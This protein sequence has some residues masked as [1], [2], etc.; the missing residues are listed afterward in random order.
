M[1][2]DPL[3][4]APV[5]LLPV[6][7][8]LAALLALDSYKLVRLRMVLLLIAGGG[9]VAVLGWFANGL[10]LR[11]TDLAFEPYSRYVAPVLEELLKGALV[12]ALLRANRIAFLVD[13]A[14]CGFAVGTGFALVENLWFLYALPDANLG[15]WILRGFGTAVM[16]GGA[17]AIFA[18]VALA[19]VER[20]GSVGPAAFLPGFAIAVALHSAF[21][22]FFGSPLFSAVGILVVLPP[23][24]LAVF[25]RSEAAVEEWIGPGFDADTELLE[26]INSGGFSDSP[27]GKYLQALRESFRGEVV[28]DLLCYVRL[29]VELGLR[30]KGLLMLHE[31][32]MDVPI[33]EATRA[34][35]E[36]LRYLERSVGPTAL[37]AIRP[38]RHLRREVWQLFM[39]GR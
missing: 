26:L 29:H 10:G 39:L 32:G 1:T 36:E 24:L 14:I 11:V 31:E 20:R 21:N 18:V 33:D 17:T 13:A 2:L 4:H 9:L 30:A 19:Q 22:H 16:H 38:F 25:R 8:F 23:L 5:G 34:K 6:A 28:A 15:V 7:C 12:V 35:F 27:V 37:L 3:V